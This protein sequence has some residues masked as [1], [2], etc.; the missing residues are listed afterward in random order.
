MNCPDCMTIL[1]RK[2]QDGAEDYI[3]M[4]ENR[5]VSGIVECNRFKAEEVAI[6]MNFDTI[7]KRLDDIRYSADGTPYSDR[8]I[9]ET[10]KPIVKMDEF[11]TLGK[12]SVLPKESPGFYGKSFVE[13]ANKV[14]EKEIFDKKAFSPEEEERLKNAVQKCVREIDLAHDPI[15]P[16]IKFVNTAYQIKPGEGGYEAVPEPK[17]RGW[18]KGKK[19]I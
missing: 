9:L 4:G 17:H 1:R 13:D 16:D 3:C 12:T 18:P 19:R 14:L 8:S 6:P 5:P 2:H 11:S 15:P 7:Q 10:M